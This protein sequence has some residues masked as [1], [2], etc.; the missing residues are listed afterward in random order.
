MTLP[1]VDTPIGSPPSVIPERTDRWNPALEAALYPSSN[2]QH[3]I[4]KLRDPR[5]L[6][7]TT[8]QQAGLFTGPSY[9]ITKALSARGLALALEK[10]WNRPVVPMYWVP[11]DDHDWQEASTAHW[12]SSDGS[13]ISASL[14]PRAPEAPMTPMWREPLGA[15]I[16]P[17]LDQFEQSF[18]E[19]GGPGPV[20]DWLRRHYAPTSTVAGAYGAAIAELLGP[21]GIL[22]LDTTHQAVKRATTPLLLRAL[23]RAQELDQLLETSDRALKQ[24]SIDAGV[25]VGDGATM[26][27]LEGELGRD[28]LVLGGKAGVFQLRRTRTSL[29]LEELHHLAKKEP[30]RFSANVLLRPV[31]ESALLP[32]VAYLAGPGELKYLEL[33]AP[34]YEALGVFRQ[35]PVPRWSGLL[36][37]PRVT[38]MLK[39][40]GIGVDELLADSSLERRLARQS[41]PEGTDAALTQL[42][43][44]IETGYAP[45]I[46]AAAA[47]DPTMESPADAAR[48]KALY[49]VDEL[50]KKLVQHARKRESVELGQVGRARLSVSPNGKPQE[51]V[52]TMPGFMA[53]YGDTVLTGLADH[54][55][56]WYG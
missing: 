45:V 25:V 27:F 53:R 28:R 39:K 26:V 44:A 55:A 29:R 48:R 46:R 10:R 56:R 1:I 34:L 36:V 22:C 38:R 7:V 43:A 8:G 11:G 2:R 47:I 54:I 40:H 12:L 14:P 17:A 15:A 4:A 32:T 16:L 13:L 19:T 41:F 21:L 24:K 9:A 35:V 23:E 37:E 3:A 6:V 51:R 50:D 42:K 18:E 5:A 52:L 33:A 30:T 31:L 20:A 49:A